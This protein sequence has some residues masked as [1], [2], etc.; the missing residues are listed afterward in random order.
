MTKPIPDDL[1]D[2]QPG[3][4]QQTEHISFTDRNVT[5]QS[6]FHFSLRREVAATSAVPKYV[7]I[8]I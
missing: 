4:G 2:S 1:F 3:A 7:L 5:L 8:N 6:H